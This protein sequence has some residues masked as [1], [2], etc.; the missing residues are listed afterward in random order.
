MLGPIGNEGEPP[1]PLQEPRMEIRKEMQPLPGEENA[2][3]KKR[4]GAEDEKEGPEPKRKCALR[5]YLIHQST[6]PGRRG[7]VRH[8]RA[9]P[10][11]AFFSCSGAKANGMGET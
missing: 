2:E 7:G 10:A 8:A 5:I 1:I 6:D 4:A 9:L 3:P 11:A